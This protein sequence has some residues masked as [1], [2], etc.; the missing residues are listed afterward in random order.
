MDQ[1]KRRT[2]LKLEDK[3]KVIQYMERGR[4]VNDIT[5]ELGI[6]K[7]QVYK[8]YKNR[9]SLLASV[10]KSGIPNHSKKVKNSAKYPDIDAAVFEWFCAVR[11]LRRSRKPLPVSQDLIKA[12]AKLEAKNKGIQTFKASNGWFWKWRNRY[13]IGPSVILHGEAGEIDLKAVE[14]TMQILREALHEFR[15]ENIFNMD[16]SALFYRAIPCRSYLMEDEGDKRQVGRGTKAMKCKDRITI[17]L[18]VNATGSCKLNPVVIG[19]AKNPRCF[20]YDHPVLPYFN[21]KKAWN[22]TVNYRK[23]WCEVFLPRVREWTS[24]PVALIIDGFSGHDMNCFDPLKQVTVF[25]FPPNVTSIYQPLDQGII[26]TLKAGYKS[27]VLAGLVGTIENFDLLQTLADQLPAGC[28]GLKYGRPPHIADAI[29]LLKESWRDIS[30]TVIDAC[31]KHSQCLSTIVT[32]D[33]LH[34]GH[35]YCKSIEQN[36]VSE[37]CK[38]LSSSLTE[39]SFSKVGIDIITQATDE[40]DLQAAVSVLLE[41]WLHLE[42]ICYDEWNESEEDTVEHSEPFVKLDLMKQALIIVSELHGV[43]VTIGD[44]SITTTAREMCIHIQESLSC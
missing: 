38:K 23:W 25:K 24:E 39:H 22:D 27:R 34:D 43:G 17:I 29:H 2:C 35:D 36:A 37:M 11:T 8:L 20:K 6:G 19:S 18:C 3:L 5:R 4:P 30:P 21:Q 40:H 9:D 14:P 7:T 13:N 44:A 10:R 33:T 42:E 1:M 32:S 16:E 28:A 12:R 41:K 15:S 31:W 26:A